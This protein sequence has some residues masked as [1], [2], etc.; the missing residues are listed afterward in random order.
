MLETR[1]RRY[2]SAFVPSTTT[3]VLWEIAKGSEDLI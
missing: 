2:G 1:S 3:G